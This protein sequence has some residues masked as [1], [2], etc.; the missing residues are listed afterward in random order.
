MT[1]RRRLPA[2][3]MPPFC[4]AAWSS[5][6]GCLTRRSF[7]GGVGPLQDSDHGLAGVGVGSESLQD[8]EQ[9]SRKNR[10]PVEQASA[11]AP[12]ATNPPR[13]LPTLTR[14]ASQESRARLTARRANRA[15]NTLWP[16][17]FPPKAVLAFF[18]QRQVVLPDH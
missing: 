2:P 5:G 7:H 8:P 15:S 6:F 18:G 16:H 4:T 9:R 13:L 17:P 10:H 11:L 3:R 12:P 1:G 14:D